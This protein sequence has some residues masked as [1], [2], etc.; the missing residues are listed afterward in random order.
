M[1]GAA[2][3]AEDADS[4]D[5]EFGNMEDGGDVK[6]RLKNTGISFQN[7]TGFSKAGWRGG[8]KR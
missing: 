6:N 8:E 4:V 1:F 7:S 3:I 5:A 2:A